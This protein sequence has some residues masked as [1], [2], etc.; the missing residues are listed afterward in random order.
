MTFAGVVPQP[1]SSDPSVSTVVSVGNYGIVGG[2][3]Q[4]SGGETQ[5][6]QTSVQGGPG[7]TIDYADPS[8]LISYM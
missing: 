3:S 8:L 4:S 2:V 1:T 7:V 5:Q 6:F